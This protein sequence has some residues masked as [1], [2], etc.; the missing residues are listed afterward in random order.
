MRV[1]VVKVN[2]KV[3]DLE[4]PILEDA[5]L[6]VL[7]FDDDEGKRVLGTPLRIFWPRLSSIY[8]RK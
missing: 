1:A 5:S 2:G 3:Q 4:Q 6:S 7:K 8:I